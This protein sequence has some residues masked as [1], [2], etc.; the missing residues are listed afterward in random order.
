MANFRVKTVALPLRV[1]VSSFLRSKPQ[2]TAHFRQLPNATI[3][4]RRSFK[5]I[6]GCPRTPHVASSWRKRR[7]VRISRC[8]SSFWEFDSSHY[9]V[10]TSLRQRRKRIHPTPLFPDI[11]TSV[12]SSLS[13]PVSV[14]SGIRVATIFLRRNFFC[15]F[16]LESNGN[17]GN[18]RR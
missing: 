6:Q 14:S 12:K 16:L 15:L 11:Q 5:E 8:K 2:W 3:R 10:L 9:R 13:F 4:I 1:Q 18:L 17:N 7:R